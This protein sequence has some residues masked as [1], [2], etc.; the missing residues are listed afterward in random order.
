MDQSVKP[1]VIATT[2]VLNIFFY[3][4][5]FRSGDITGGHGGGGYTDYSEQGVFKYV[6]NGNGIIP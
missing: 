4:P 2:A 6:I 3:F 5:G 1:K